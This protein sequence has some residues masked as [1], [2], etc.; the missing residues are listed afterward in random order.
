MIELDET[1]SRSIRAVYGK[2]QVE[3][4]LPEIVIK[5]DRHNVKWH[6]EF[7]NLSR[8]A[9]AMQMIRKATVILRKTLF[10]GFKSTWRKNAITEENHDST[11]QR[12]VG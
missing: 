8:R 5:Y 11:K 7:I 3:E 4:Y 1:G 12:Q 10:K 9:L 6:V 2:E